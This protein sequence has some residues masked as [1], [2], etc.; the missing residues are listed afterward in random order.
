MMLQ[1]YTVLV[2]LDCFTEAAEHAPMTVGQVVYR[3]PYAD[4]GLCGP[5]DIPVMVTPM[6]VATIYAVPSS[7]LRMGEVVDLSVSVHEGIG[8]TPPAVMPV[9]FSCVDSLP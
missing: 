3:W 9:K 2:A 7:A 8:H 1:T 6:D 5:D 4:W